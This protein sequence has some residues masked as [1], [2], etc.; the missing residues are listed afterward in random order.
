[1]PAVVKDFC[2]SCFESYSTGGWLEPGDRITVVPTPDCE[3]V[4]H[5][6]NWT[7]R[8][9]GGNLVRLGEPT[10][11]AREAYLRWTAATF[12]SLVGGIGGE[13]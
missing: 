4:T 9:T 8:R 11:S 1:M 12:R 6:W 5:D 10:E 2:R 13:G 3:G 7:R